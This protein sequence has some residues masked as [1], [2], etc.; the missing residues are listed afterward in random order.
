M[1]EVDNCEMLYQT[2]GRRG[3]G[4]EVAKEGGKRALFKASR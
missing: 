3:K 4:E 1:R 2:W